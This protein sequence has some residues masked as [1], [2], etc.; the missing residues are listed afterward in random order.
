M[1]DVSAD[2]RIAVASIG[3]DESKIAF[4]WLEAVFTH[5]NDRLRFWDLST[6]KVLATTPYLSGEF[7]G[8]ARLSLSGNV[9]ATYRVGSGSIL[10]F[11]IKHLPTAEKP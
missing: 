3:L 9:V 1:L 4:L 8:A 11:E 6:G 5:K 7:A 10:F 2:V